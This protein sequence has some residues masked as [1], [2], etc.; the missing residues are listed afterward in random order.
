MF[1]NIWS[2]PK[3]FLGV[4]GDGSTPPPGTPPPAAPTITAE[5]I[6]ALKDDGF[7]AILPRSLRPSPT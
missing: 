7:R 2:F 6:G 4:D 1:K 3:F 5:S